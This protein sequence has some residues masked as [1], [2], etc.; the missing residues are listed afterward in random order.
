MSKIIKNVENAS[1]SKGY[2]INL[3]KF[4]K[5]DG[6]CPKYQSFCLKMDQI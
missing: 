6:L 5:I 1:P 3:S 2:T 4:L